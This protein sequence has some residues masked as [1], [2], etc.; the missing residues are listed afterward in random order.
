VT[1]RARLADYAQPALDELQDLQQL[2]SI[3]A[4]KPRYLSTLVTATDEVVA[5]SQAV[6]SF[7][8][9]QFSR[10]ESEHANHRPGPTIIDDATACPLCTRY[11]KDVRLASE[12]A[13]ACRRL[14]QLVGL[15]VK[16]AYLV[17]AD[18][19][20]PGG[21]ARAQAAV[22]FRREVREAVTRIQ[23]DMPKLP[24]RN[25]AS[26]VENQLE[27]SGKA[28]RSRRTIKRI[29]KLHTESR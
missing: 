10:S 20:K 7:V 21:D 13:Q 25:L 6:V 22:P 5:T 24:P 4:S 26:K 17:H 9:E 11:R 1:K 3:R 15:Y 14:Q 19:A 18:A 8:H 27:L 23:R 12:V 16:R 2:M 28:E 29:I